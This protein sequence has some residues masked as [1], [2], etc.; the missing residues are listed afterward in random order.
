MAFLK[1]CVYARFM[2]DW[3]FDNLAACTAQ[4]RVLGFWRDHSMPSDLARPMEVE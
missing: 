1:T 4:F 2:S 3:Q